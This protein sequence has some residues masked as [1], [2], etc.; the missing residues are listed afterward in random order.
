[1]IEAWLDRPNVHCLRGCNQRSPEMCLWGLR[2]PL[3]RASALVNLRWL[4]LRNRIPGGRLYHG[5]ATADPV[6]ALQDIPICN[7][8]LTYLESMR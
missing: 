4:A 2:T 5:G 7:D 8:Q 3:Y 1:M 6:H